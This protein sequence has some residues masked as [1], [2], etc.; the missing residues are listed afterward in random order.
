MSTRRGFTLV[1][2]LLT[3]GIIAVLATVVV[4]SLDPIERFQDARQLS[5]IQR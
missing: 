2:I 5:L 4:V 1:E 3:I